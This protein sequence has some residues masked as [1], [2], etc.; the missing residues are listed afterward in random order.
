MSLV[1]NSEAYR[2]LIREDLDWLLRQ[3]RT[4]ERDHIQQILEWQMEYAKAVVAHERAMAAYE[5]A[6]KESQP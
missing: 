1:L 5:Q 4:L 6:K 3:P 2:K